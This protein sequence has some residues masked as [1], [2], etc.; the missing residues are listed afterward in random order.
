MK[1]AFLGKDWPK[2]LVN[3]PGIDLQKEK[4]ESR[5]Q[6]GIQQK[7]RTSWQTNLF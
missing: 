7:G 4:L 5:V 3:P 1:Y 6:N 2:I